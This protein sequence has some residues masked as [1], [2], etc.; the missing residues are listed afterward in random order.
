GF[1]IEPGE[2]E[3]VLAAHPAV[4]RAV[5]LAR[6]AAGGGKRLLGWVVPE[7]G[8]PAEPDLLAYLAARLPAH[9]VPDAVT[10]LGEL[11]LTA[12]GKV[13]RRALPDPEIEAGAGE[14]PATPSEELLAELWSELL[15]VPAVARDDEFFELGG[16]SLLATRLV[17]R[18]R[19]AAGVDLPLRA[20]FDSP[21]LEALGRA[22]DAARGEA[23]EPV[24]PVTGDGPR[25]LSFAQQRLW[26]LDR[27][28]P[29]DTAYNMPA[30]LHLRGELEAGLLARVF[31]EI[32]RRHEVLRTRFT[33]GSALAEGPVQLVEP[34]AA[35]PLPVIDLRRL[36]Q[37]A[38]AKARRLAVAEA[39]RPF[40]LEH[41]PVLRTALL[42]L[43][44]AEH[45]LLLDLH[46]IVSDGWSMG[47]LMG[48]VAAL[49]GAF[50]EG[51]RSPLPELSVQY[52][53][54]ARWQRR[55]LPPERIEA[56]LEVWRR[57]LAG[58]PE[59]LELPT[60]RPR[61][62][63]RSHRGSSVPVRLGR[64]TS[65]A[66][67]ALAGRLGATPF[68]VLSAAFAALLGRAAGQ[69]EV[70]VGSPV[71]GRPRRE[72]EPLVGFF[73]NTLP[74][75]VEL[76][77]GP[78]FAELVVRQRAVAL[79]AFAHAEIPFERLVEE[80]APRRL[81]GVTPLYQV[82]FALQ[83]APGG[84]LEL[85]GLVLE[86]WAPPSRSAK[87]DLTLS[88]SRGED[89]FAGSLELDL[90]L[91][92]RTTVR[93]LAHGF[94][95]LLAGAVATPERPVAELSVMA[96]AERHQVL[97][98]WRGTE[99]SYPR[100][101]ALPELFARAVARAPASPA[102]AAPGKGGETG[103]YGALASESRRLA[104]RLVAAGVRRGDRVAVLLDR[105]PRLVAVLLGILEAGAAYVPL[106]PAYPAER[107]R[108]LLD[109]CSATVLVTA[110]GLAGDLLAGATSGLPT[111]LDL[112]TE[113]AA[114]AA[115]DDA[116]LG[117]SLDPLDLAY[118]L[119]TSGST[120]RPK[121][122]AV[123]HRAVTRLVLEARWAELSAAETF[124]LLAPV[125]FDASTLEIW[126]AL[127]HGAKLVLYPERVPTLGGLSA[128]LREQAVSVLWLTAG[129]FHL[130]VDEAL[131]A[132]AGVRQVLAG[133]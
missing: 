50:A 124:L 72:L 81:A 112:D 87:F 46:H 59:L 96:A 60:D 103:S 6:P 74:L 10:V 40:D 104:R 83:N 31:A 90:D 19:D 20:V 27:L 131:D 68:M 70:V 52:A 18:L 32:V 120:G 21:S 24:V 14:P 107:L 106:D 16:H 51:R 130:V 92:D 93:R 110:G 38:A 67:E 42:R 73:V 125:S 5:V 54:Y 71:A 3:A 119:Y 13:D 45:L 116:P 105:E 86:P 65:A 23:D 80:L 85:P 30:A 17:S 36:G 9:M 97:V 88:L 79:E 111:V 58:A 28:E 127:L 123:P 63:L 53:D 2:V 94:E 78:S 33:E 98:E 129:L 34:P 114:V 121:G 39:G 7:P 8:A 75:R 82:V 109:D 35:V 44:P 89:G 15:G 113:A 115:L 108:L 11:P 41:G 48:E 77:G 84:E 47:V 69:R 118:V 117:L 22:L 133:G 91:F 12:N 57:R 76:G 128:V 62:G 43:A 56:E 1:R 99:T 55:R 126:G 122:V 26:F 101:A 95:L 4:A 100:Q 132:L 64:A 37:D 66:L 29:G 25:P 61:P 49:Y 102:L